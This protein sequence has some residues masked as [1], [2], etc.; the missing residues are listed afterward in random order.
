M[1]EIGIEGRFSGGG[2]PD[3]WQTAVREWEAV[4]ATH[5]SVNTM[6]LGLASPREHI[7]Q[8]RRVKEGLE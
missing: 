8:I 1:A 3:D 4:G 5:L 2:T 7:E 6:G